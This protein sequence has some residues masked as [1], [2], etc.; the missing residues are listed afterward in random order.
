[1]GW[2]QW[3][4]QVRQNLPNR[5]RLGAEADQPDSTTAI[6]AAV[7]SEKSRDTKRL[8]IPGPGHSGGQ[9]V[10]HRGSQVLPVRGL[11]GRSGSRVR[12]QRRRNDPQAPQ[13]RLAHHSPDS[14]ATASLRPRIQPLRSAQSHRPEAPPR[15][16]LSQAPELVASGHYC[17]YDNPGRPSRCVAGWWWVK[18]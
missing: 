14:T 11:R 16:P 18:R 17:R 6:K 2:L 1:M 8:I 13:R 9:Q 12:D 10:E 5:L 3:L 15:G 4:T 7:F